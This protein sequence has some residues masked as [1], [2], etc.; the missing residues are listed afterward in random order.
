VGIAVSRARIA[1]AAVFGG[2]GDR[3]TVPSSMMPCCSSQAR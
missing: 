1:W 2:V 3:E